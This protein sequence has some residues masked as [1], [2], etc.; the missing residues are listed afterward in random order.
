MRII[1]VYFSFQGQVFL[2]TR[3]MPYKE[4]TVPS[5]GKYQIANQETQAE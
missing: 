3:L 1:Q 4:R 5:L 2:E